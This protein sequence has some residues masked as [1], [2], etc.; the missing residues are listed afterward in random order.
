MA[1]TLTRLAGSLT[2]TLLAY[3]LYKVVKLIYDEVTS[4]L[5]DL[6]GPKSS[7]WIYGNFKEIWEAVSTKTDS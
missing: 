5:R 1:T 6:S 2:A 7:S 3:G 4:P